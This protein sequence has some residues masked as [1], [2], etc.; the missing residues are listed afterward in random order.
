MN[1]Y[2]EARDALSGRLCTFRLIG[3]ALVADSIAD[4]FARIAPTAKRVRSWGNGAFQSTA[5]AAI[6][7]AGFYTEST[8][9]LEPRRHYRL[10]VLP[11]VTEGNREELLAMRRVALAE[12]SQ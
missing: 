2:R 11:V 3:A 4:E 6:R 10:I 7:A 8:L 1:D 12:L 5:Y 9:Q